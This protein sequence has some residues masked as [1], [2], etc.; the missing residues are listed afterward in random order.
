MKKLKIG[1]HGS[2]EMTKSLLCLFCK[3]NAHSAP[4]EVDNTAKAI[5]FLERTQN[6]YYLAIFVDIKLMKAGG[7]GMLGWYCWRV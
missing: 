6:C 4:Q 2:R 1:D 3:E 7:G 5:V